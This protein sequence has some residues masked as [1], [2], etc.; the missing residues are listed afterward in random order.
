MAVAERGF[1]HVL[2]QVAALPQTEGFVENGTV[3]IHY[4]IYGSGVPLLFL[5]GF[6]DVALGWANQI[7]EFVQDYQVITPTLRGYPPSSVPLGPESYTIPELVSDV[8]AVLTALQMD[9]ALMVGNDWGGVVLQAVALYYPAKVQG[10]ALLNSPVLRPF[11][12]LVNSDPEQQAMS[13]YT[14]AYQCYSEGDDKNIAGVVSNIRDPEWRGQIASYLGAS[15]MHGMLSYYKTA[16]PTP[17]YLPTASE[18]RAQYICDVPTLI[19]WGLEDPYFSPKHL[20]SL[21]KWFTQSY[22]FVSV[23][24][25]GHWV[26]QDAPAK[27]NAELRSWLESRPWDTGPEH[28][29]SAS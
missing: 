23:P 3:R 11:I 6:P 1:T 15:P 17:P 8:V 9:R 12:E 13:A 21:W 5:H 19:V 7:L 26:H 28:G 4:R 18:D 24:S 14:I 27:V 22:R 16:Y 29:V 2:T 20:S 10:L 25:A